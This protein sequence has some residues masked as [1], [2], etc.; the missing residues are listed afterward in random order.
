MP[1]NQSKLS[2]KYIKLLSDYGYNVTEIAD[3]GKISIETITKGFVDYF[4]KANKVLIR[5]KN[6]WIDNGLN[7]IKTNLVDQLDFIKYK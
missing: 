2:Y 5:Q 4:P 7:W 6:K 3:K 1:I